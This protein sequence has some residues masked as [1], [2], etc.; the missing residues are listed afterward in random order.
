MKPRFTMKWYPR[1]CPS[2]VSIVLQWFTVMGHESRGWLH[3]VI[4]GWCC[5]AMNWRARSPLLNSTIH[6]LIRTEGEL[7][8]SVTKEEIAG[9]VEK[10]GTSATDTGKTE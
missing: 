4:Q 8:M 6:T 2:G 5:R 3:A 9:I 1:F 7:Y 10:F